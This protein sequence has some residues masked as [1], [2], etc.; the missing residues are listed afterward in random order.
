VIRKLQQA[1]QFLA[2]MILAGAGLILP[3]VR[4]EGSGK[5]WEVGDPK[6]MGLDGEAFNDH[7]E[8]CERSG[9]EACLVAYKGKIVSEWYSRI[10]TS[11]SPACRTRRR[12]R[13]RCLTNR[14]PRR[15]FGGWFS[16]DKSAGSSPTCRAS[17]NS[18]GL[19]LSPTEKLPDQH[20]YQSDAYSN[21]SASNRAAQNLVE[22]VVPPLEFAP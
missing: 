8:L 21:D 13:E 22:H 5:D 12:R 16:R 18:A 15:S 7:R 10:S 20:G 4:G 3:A 17:G 11:S 2:L 14:R 9:A 6:A 1:V 19:A